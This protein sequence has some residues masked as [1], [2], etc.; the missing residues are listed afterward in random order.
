MKSNTLNSLIEELNKLDVLLV[1][2]LTRKLA[3]VGINDIAL[4]S[5]SLIFGVFLI[6]I[7]ES[8]KRRIPGKKYRS[9]FLKFVRMMNDIKD[10]SNFIDENW[11]NDTI[12]S[13][14]YAVLLSEDEIN[15]ISRSI[16]I[17]ARSLMSVDNYNEP[18]Q[19]VLKLAEELNVDLSEH[20][21]SSI[22]HLKRLMARLPALNERL[23]ERMLYLLVKVYKLWESYK[24]EITPPLTKRMLRTARRLQLISSKMS[25]DKALKIIRKL[26]TEMFPH[27]PTK[28]MALDLVAKKWCHRKPKCLECPL[29]ILCPSL[30]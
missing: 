28:I 15:K 8:I 17:F 9:M 14:N 16:S 24:R 26:G 12:S 13:M 19:I 21:G 5:E 30:V 27:D 4:K 22:V 3:G 18:Q 23:S 10:L 6:T 1:E 2:E 7:F 20:N 29:Y 25:K 11:V